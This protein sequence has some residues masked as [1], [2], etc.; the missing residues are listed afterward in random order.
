[1]S[2]ES[3]AELAADQT[4]AQRLT[5]CTSEQ[6]Q[7]FQNDPEPAVKSLADRILADAGLGLSWFLWPV[8]TAPGFGD[9][10]GQEN[11]TDGQLLAAVQTVWPTVAAIHPD[12]P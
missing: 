1:M 6:A 7:A 10:D 3:Q 9:A 11:I 4:F 2:Y 12:E 5:A 8:A